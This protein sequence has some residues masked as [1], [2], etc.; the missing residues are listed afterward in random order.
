MNYPRILKLSQANLA[1]I[2]LIF[3]YF[4]E[5]ISKFSIVYLDGKSN[6]PRAIK[7]LV[8]LFLLF[9]IIKPI[10]NFILPVLLFVFFIIGQ[11]FI[12]NGFS[13]E[14]VISFSKFLFP[15]F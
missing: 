7:F 11:L 2:F 15:V 10:R 5:A 8:L 1:A 6:L 4:S 13:K 3:F 12:D 9:K 14:I